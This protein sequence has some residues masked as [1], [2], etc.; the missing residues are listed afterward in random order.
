MTHW[1]TVPLR[2]PNRWSARHVLEWHIASDLVDRPVAIA[3]NIADQLD[4]FLDG[5]RFTTTH[6]KSVEIARL[7]TMG[8]RS[9]TR[10]GDAWSAIA[11]WMSAMAG[12]PSAGLPVEWGSP[13][14]ILA[15][16]MEEELLSDRCFELAESM[17]VAFENDEKFALPV[18]FRELF[19]YADDVRLGPSS[20]A[21]LQAASARGIPSYR[22]N[23]GS[24]V[25]LGEG[26]LQRR[27][28]TAETDA[29]SAIA[30]S[31]ASDK[32]L[33]KRLLR[34]VGVPVPLGRMV[35]SP[36]DAWCAAQE[37]GFPVVVKPRDANH[38]RG[39]SIELTEREE[40]I[41]A[42]HWAIQD[43][44]TDDVMVEQFAR[45]QH[46]RL[47]VV[48]DAM[49]AASCGHVETVLGDG[50]RTV[51][52]L[53]DSLNQDP[54]RGEAYA[55]PLSVVR[56]EP[57]SQIELAKQGLSVDAIPE[58]GRVVLVHRNG[59]LT[60]D[61]TDAVHPETARQAV[62]AAR[63]VGLDVAGLDV[64]ATDIGKPLAEQRG[65]VVEVN[66]G[67]SLSSHVSPL[68]GRP[69]PV[70]SAILG[71]LFPA[72]STGRIPIVG[73]VVSAGEE[74]TLMV[75][76]VAAEYRMLGHSVA[77]IE[78]EGIRVADI[79]IPLPQC[80]LAERVQAALSHPQVDVVIVIMEREALRSAACPTPR[81]DRVIMTPTAQSDFEGPKW[82]AARSTLRH[83][84][85]A[86]PI[87]Y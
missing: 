41:R 48:G 2:G 1:T 9:A 10:R 78:S 68:F 27:I 14:S 24:L 67:P 25:Q 30:E 70:G 53:V 45:G 4:A 40:I 32:D 51:S 23:R 86:P 49:I 79:H 59:D 50:V 75:D 69:Q 54:R 47:L 83:A 62:L 34:N 63:V 39:I 52:Q 64:L 43:G 13:T 33:T 3:A 55:D 35:T 19:D 85:L 37:V 26:R 42:Y 74:P 36:E 60:T 72:Q 7:R 82:L 57:A 22:M 80:S 16:E 15:L 20:R 21:I 65:A 31:I 29:T 61:C 76:E 71:M 46:H 87:E 18:K 5:G 11:G 28:W 84:T 8:L 58:S 81:L 6:P 73:I 44:Q 17:L 56:L 66:A 12:V 38:Q 77:C